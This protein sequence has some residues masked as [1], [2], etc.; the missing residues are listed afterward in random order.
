MLICV[1]ESSDGVDGG[2]MLFIA[3]FSA[4][5]TIWL[6]QEGAFDSAE[7]CLRF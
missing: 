4:L 2:I 5:F 7:C 1:A 6:A 3:A